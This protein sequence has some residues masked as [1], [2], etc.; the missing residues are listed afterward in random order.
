LLNE[1]IKDKSEFQGEI[2]ER[3]YFNNC[4]TS[5]PA[6][7]VVDE[8]IPYLREDFYFPG[9]FIKCG[10]AIAKKVEDWKAL[11]GST[12]GAS[13]NEIHFTSGG[14][15]ANNIAIKGFLS[16]NFDKGNHIICS[17]VDYPDI[18]TN[19]SFFEQSGFE[20]T[21]LPAD[22]D[23]YVDLGALEAS[24]RKNTVLFM[25]TLVNHTMGT[26]QR[27]KD[28]K[29]ILNKSHDKIYVMA[30]AC[31]AYARMPINVDELGIDLMSISAHKIHGPQGIGALYQRKGVTL[32]PVQHGVKRIDNH[33]TGGI[34]VA[35]CAGFAKAVELAFDDL[36][37]KIKYMYDLAD[38]MI[39]RILTEIPDTEINGP[40]NGERACHN[41]N[42]SIDYIEG[43]AIMVMLDMFNI[44]VA[45]GSACASQG[46]KANYVLT[47][48]GRTHVQSHGS[49]KFTTSRY[50]TI[51]EID[52]TVDKLKEI[53]EKL[54]SRSPL[55]HAAK[56][57]F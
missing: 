15:A 51:E 37:G 50:N 33:N 56:K 49:M 41:I 26:I 10:S 34:S 5:Q 24:I 55:Y 1:I 3:V 57:N 4:L 29:K 47:S 6:P 25:T 40:K 30:D 54:R 43:E 17:V 52:Y 2:M 46:L 19:A 16:A 27:M 31:E 23:G 42:I 13:A 35:L 20:V 8:M 45:T 22:K 11:I 39:N 14:T 53:V 38:H 32:A 21:Y 44:M 12:I 36:D 9:N 28:F 48:T 18:L 7:E